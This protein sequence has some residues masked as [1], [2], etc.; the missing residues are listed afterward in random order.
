MKTWTGPKTSNLTFQ[1]KRESKKLFRLESVIKH[2]K[3][4][5]PLKGPNTTRRNGTNSKCGG[6]FWGGGEQVDSNQTWG[7]CRGGSKGGQVNGREK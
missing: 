4:W 3:S 2:K 1:Y 6:S 7:G 5:R